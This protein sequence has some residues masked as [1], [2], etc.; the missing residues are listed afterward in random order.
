MLLQAAPFATVLTLKSTNMNRTR[1]FLFCCLLLPFTGMAQK[2]Q[3]PTLTQETIQ[4]FKK[5]HHSVIDLEPQR[6]LYK[7]SYF[8]RFKELGKIYNPL[9]PKTRNKIK[10][11]NY[12]QQG[13]ELIYIGFSYSTFRATVQLKGRV[14]VFY[15]L[16]LGESCSS[17]IEYEVKR[18]GDYLNITGKVYKCFSAT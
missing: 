2:A 17:L 6:I 16:W 18:D 10:V 5:N 15:G 12:W 1:F 4:D 14:G 9:F 7:D 3:Q 13:S 11:E 8:V